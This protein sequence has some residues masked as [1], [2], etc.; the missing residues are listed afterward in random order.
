VTAGVCPQCAGP[1]RRARAVY[2]GQAC[3]EAA[4]GARRAGRLVDAL[5]LLRYGVRLDVV[6]AR[7]G[8]QVDT[9]LQS[10]DLGQATPGLLS[11][12]DLQALRRLVR[13]DQARSWEDAHA[14]LSDRAR[15]W[16]WTS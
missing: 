10:V 14:E 16:R 9:L 1:L 13:A 6:A 2:C 7:L 12:L 15:E 3:L 4:R 11:D 8:V 5:H